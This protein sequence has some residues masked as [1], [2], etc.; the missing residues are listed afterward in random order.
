L[1]E[2]LHGGRHC[3]RTT[4]FLGVGLDD[5][6]TLRLSGSCYIPV[7]PQQQQ[8]SPKISPATA[9]AIPFI[10]S[11]QHACASAAQ[12]KHEDYATA[13]AQPDRLVLIA[14][15]DSKIFGF[16]VAYTGIPEWELENIAVAPDVRR[17]GVGHA[18]ITALIERARQGGATEIRQEIRESSTAAQKLGLSAGFIQEGRRPD[19][20]RD[21]VEDALLFKHLLVRP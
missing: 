15:K 14:E 2:T 10:L 7:V 11:I 3:Y 16:V 9:A 18:L 6:R 20:Y 19:Y 13:I 5:P 17:C 4:T 8:M 1:V 21:P 12:W